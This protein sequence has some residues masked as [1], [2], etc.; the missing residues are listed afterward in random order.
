[1]RERLMPLEDEKL[2]DAMSAVQ[3]QQEANMA[4]LTIAND[5]FP[6]S[7]DVQ[8]HTF[9]FLFIHVEYMWTVEDGERVEYMLV[10]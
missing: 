7:K 8:V 4:N 10:S 9:I 5:K 1:M 6:D 3:H 2:I